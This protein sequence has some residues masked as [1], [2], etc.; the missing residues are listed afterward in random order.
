MKMWGERQPITLLIVMQ[1]G[2]TIVKDNM[3]FFFFR[4]TKIDLS[5]DSDIPLL[6]IC[7]FKMK[8]SYERGSCT[9]MFIAA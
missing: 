4:N 2:T 1:T 7:S 6:E 3:E 9:Y 5:C 8:S